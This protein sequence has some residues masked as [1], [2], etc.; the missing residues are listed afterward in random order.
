MKIPCLSLWL[1]QDVKCTKLESSNINRHVETYPKDGH[2]ILIMK[3]GLITCF[4]NYIN[5]RNKLQHTIVSQSFS[6]VSNQVH[7]EAYSKSL[8]M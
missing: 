5:L 3:T 7:E 2:V 6:C 1:F 4:K 8:N